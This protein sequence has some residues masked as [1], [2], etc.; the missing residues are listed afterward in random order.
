MIKF[1]VDACVQKLKPV[2]HNNKYTVT[3]THMH[4][5]TDT[6]TVHID[7]QSHLSAGIRL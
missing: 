3:Y 7:R 4:T 6:D 5:H 2:T 1:L